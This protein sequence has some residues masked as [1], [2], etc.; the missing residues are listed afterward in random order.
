MLMSNPDHKEEKM[1]KN[2]FFPVCN[3]NSD[4]DSYFFGS[5]FDKV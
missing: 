5:F 2:T 3:Q 4:I 1:E